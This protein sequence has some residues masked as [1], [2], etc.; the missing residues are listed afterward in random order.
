MKWARL[1]RYTV[2]YALSF[3]VLYLFGWVTFLIATDI[4]HRVLHLERFLERGT[5]S[6][7]QALWT[8]AIYVV[9]PLLAIPITRRI[10]KLLSKLRSRL[11]V[12]Q[13]TSTD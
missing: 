3:G 1:L 13:K 10:D 8:V 9:S 11:A 6:T 2:I 7:I 12:Y 4:A 5:Y